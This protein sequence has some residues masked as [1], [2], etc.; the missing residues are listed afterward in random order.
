MPVEELVTKVPWTADASLHAKALHEST[1]QQEFYEPQPVIRRVAVIGAGP[2]GLPTAKALRDEGIDVTIYERSPKSGGTWIYNPE[3][4]VTP[5]YPST[6]PS[7]LIQASLPPQDAPLPFSMTALLDEQSRDALLRHAPPTPCYESLRNNVATPLIRY[8]DLGWPENTPWFTTH[9]KILAYLQDYSATFGLDGVTEYNTSVERLTE[10]PDKQG[11][12]VLTKKMVVQHEEND[13]RVTSTW[14]ED[15]F[16]S[17]VVA[18]GHYHAPHIPDIRG[19][20]EWHQRYPDAIL[21]SKQYRTPKGYDGKTVLLVGD[22]TS[23]L[24]IARDIGSRVKLIYQSVR[25]TDHGYDEKYKAFREEVKTW[26]PS[27]VERVDVIQEIIYDDQAA[28][29]PSTAAT[30]VLQDGRRLQGVDV[31]IICTGYLFNYHFLHHLHLDEGID[32]SKRPHRDEALVNEQ[33][34]QLYNLHKDIFYI[35]NPLRLAFVG[36]P[37]H[38]ATFSF[39]EFQAFAVARVFSGAAAL[40]TERAMRAEWHDREKKKGSGRE[41]HALGAELEQAYISD[42]LDWLNAHGIPRGKKKLLGHDEAWLNVKENAFDALKKEFKTR[43]N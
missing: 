27:N 15:I 25:N 31:I 20:A 19:L 4:P 38:I 30:I 1:L 2:A 23:A 42:I 33:G 28:P 3:P 13:T 12:R 18:T 16:D 39:F 7:T 34:N 22:G 40:P 17:V 24:D 32:A 36:L 41:F 29:S 43:L 21:H 9:D 35:P 8:K 5:A 6:V 11:W 14:K 10:L 37:F 26:L